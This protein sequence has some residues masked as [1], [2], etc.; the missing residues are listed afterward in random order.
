MREGLRQS[1]VHAIAPTSRVVEDDA[2]VA[3]SEALAA[4]EGNV[5]AGALEAV[6]EG[7]TVALGELTSDTDVVGD[8]ETVA[9]GNATLLVEG[10][11]YGALLNL[12]VWGG[13]GLWGSECRD[14]EAGCQE[15]EEE[16]LEGHHVGG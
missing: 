12:L 5:V 13:D 4:P 2:H 11:G 7:I 9:V 6:P 14:H 16:G 15:G 3:T 1:S 8:E 10:N